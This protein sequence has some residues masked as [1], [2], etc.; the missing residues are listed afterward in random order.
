MTSASQS[1]RSRP[2]PTRP[3][4][5]AGIRARMQIQIKCHL[6]RQVQVQ[7][8]ALRRRHDVRARIPSWFRRCTRIRKSGPA[9]TSAFQPSDVPC[10]LST[11]TDSAM[12]RYPTTAARMPQIAS[13]SARN[14]RICR[15]AA[16]ASAHP[17]TPRA[18]PQP[19][20]LF[21]IAVTK[22]RIHARR[23]QTFAARIRARKPDKSA[24]N[25][26]ARWTCKRPVKLQNLYGIQ[27][28]IQVYA[29]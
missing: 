12:R 9:R 16:K 1:A 20:M 3:W 6:Q 7:L 15:S 22:R 23:G 10:R 27:E 28:P 29:G 25:A 26:E 21:L 5:L 14:Q 2:G 11:G 17:R 4:R 8:R 19:P 24:Q 18:R 13:A